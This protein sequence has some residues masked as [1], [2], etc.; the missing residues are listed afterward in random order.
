MIFLKNKT[1]AVTPAKCGAQR[2]FGIFL[3]KTERV[4]CF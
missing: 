2:A 1:I 4:F 3:S